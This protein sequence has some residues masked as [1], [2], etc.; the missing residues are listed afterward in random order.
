MNVRLAKQLWLPL[1]VKSDT[2]VLVSDVEHPVGKEQLMERVLER[3]NVVP[4]LKR[5]EQNKGSAGVDGMKVEELRP[6][7]KENWPAIRQE[8]LNGR[9]FP[10]PVRRSKIPK[11]G[12]GVRKFRAP[13][14]A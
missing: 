14:M 9:Y 2:F 3:E 8:L 1:S 6:F 13:D 10:Q 4:A 5:V 12:G 7:L 11:P